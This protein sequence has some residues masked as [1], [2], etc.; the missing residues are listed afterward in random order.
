MCIVVIAVLLFGLRGVP[1]ADEQLRAIDVAHAIADEENA[2]LVYGRIILDETLPSLAPRDLPADVQEATFARPWRSEEFPQAT[3]WINQRKG[4]VEILLQAGRKQGCWFPA[5]EASKQSTRRWSLVMEGKNLLLRAA[6]NDMGENRVEEGL[7]KLL[8]VFQMAEHFRSQFHPS[9]YDASMIVTSEALQ[10]LA[11]LA[12]R[13]DM[14][15]DWLI[16]FESVL[17]PLEETWYEQSKLL[18]KAEKLY[19]ESIGRNSLT[20]ILHVFDRTRRREM[21]RNY[22]LLLA[23][24]RA[25][26]V[27]LELR[28]HKNETGS[29]PEDLEEIASHVAPEALID[30]ETGEP[31][32]YRRT[33]DTFTL[34]S[35]GA[36][37]R[38]EGGNAGDDHRFW[39]R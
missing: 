16:R 39:P 28:R 36:N 3:A 25:V 32:K 27:L 14:P 5:A 22:F 23:K 19:M 8:C 21:E 30:P 13:G 17:P 6:N 2:A 31:F 9:D 33:N 26:R 35:I 11:E 1:S 20:Q 7:E 18:Y 10:R 38:D 4:V 29:W 24:S 15:P 37:R 34:Y 12:I